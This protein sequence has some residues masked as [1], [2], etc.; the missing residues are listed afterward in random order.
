M[1]RPSKKLPKDPNKLAYEIVRM[2]T[3][4]SEE[5]LCESQPK[6]KNPIKSADKSEE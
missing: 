1:K 2:S 3:E 5:D 4:D 6:L